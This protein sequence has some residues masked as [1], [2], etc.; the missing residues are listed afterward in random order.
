[1]PLVI[2]L[3]QKTAKHEYD[4]KILYDDEIK[5]I[6]EPS[7]KYTTS[8][9]KAIGEFH[10]YK[11]KQEPSFRVVL[12]NIR[13]STNVEILKKIIENRDHVVTNVTN[14]NSVLEINR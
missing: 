11:R 3:L 2:N 12:R 5:I 6:S 1:M 4:L 8:V 14:M 7:E 9:V 13:R 10:T